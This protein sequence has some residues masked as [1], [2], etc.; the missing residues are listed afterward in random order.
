LPIIPFNKAQL[1]PKR[2]WPK[3]FW[4]VAICAVVLVGCIAGFVTVGEKA[5]LTRKQS[6]S[7]VQIEALVQQLSTLTRSD[8]IVFPDGRVWYVRGVQ[9]SNMEVVGW[10]GNNAKSED[11]YSFVLANDDFKIVRQGDPMW[12]KNRDDYFKQ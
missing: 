5:A 8:L 9:G 1:R 10:I 12:A 2:T 7:K 11:I 3:R 4:L 6:P